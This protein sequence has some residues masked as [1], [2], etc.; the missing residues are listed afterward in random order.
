MI[1][2]LGRTIELEHREKHAQRPKR[3][4]NCIV[5]VM[6]LSPRAA[7]LLAS[8]GPPPK[9][10]GRSPAPKP[11]HSCWSYNQQPIQP[12][13]NDPSWCAKKTIPPS[14]DICFM[15]QT[16][17]TVPFAKGT[18]DNQKCPISAPK[19]YANA[20]ATG[21]STKPAINVPRAR[22]IQLS[23]IGLRIRPP[24]DRPDS[25]QGY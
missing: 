21:I 12:P 2:H 4:I 15:P 14:I 16:L 3:Y 8:L 25:C 9:D 5:R 7:R 20:A 1:D 13:A 23:N 11:Y 10:L 18:V 22:Y 17:A 24:K 6:P 19:T